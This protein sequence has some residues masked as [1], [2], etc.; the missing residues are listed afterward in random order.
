MLEFISQFF[1]FDDILKLLKEPEIIAVLITCALEVVRRNIQ[2]KANVIWGIPH[3]FTF[4]IPQ[5]NGTSI[6]MHTS[7][8]L[9]RNSGRAEARDVEFYFNFKPEH[10]EIWPI[11]EFKTDTTSD[12][13][14]IIKIPFIKRNEFFTIEL[15]QA[16]AQTPELLNVRAI[17]GRC[18]NVNMA[19]MQIFP[20]WIN[21]I[22]CSL[23]ILGVYQSIVWIVAAFQ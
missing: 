4:R 18:K 14:Y 12:G 15:I 16:H 13:R 10:F 22:I 3:G 20:H 17:E 8:I 5:Q 7:S 2:P 21:A 19:P 23:L 6:L 11:I 1:T 9:V